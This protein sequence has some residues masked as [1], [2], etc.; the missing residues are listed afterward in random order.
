MSTAPARAPLV[1]RTVPLADPGRLLPL[2]PASGTLAWVRR[3]EGLVGWGSAVRIRTGGEQRFAAAEAAWAELTRYAVVRDE[4]GLPGTGP[5]AFGY[6]AFSP[7]SRA[8]GVLVVPEIVVGH[9]AGQWWVTTVGTGAVLPRIR[10]PTPQGPPSSPGDVA[11][12]DGARSAPGWERVVATAIERIGRGEV[13]KVVLAR[14]LE[15][16]AERPVDPRWL[17]G[18]LADRYPGCW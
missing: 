1:A 11:F 18:R 3:D 4:V 17:L 7:R 5:V 6:F 13:E 12:A 2:L 15:A 16:I 9:R 8:G 14:D 10:T